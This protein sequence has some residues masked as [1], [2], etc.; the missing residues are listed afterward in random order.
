[1]KK[2][3]R[4]VVWAM[5][6][7]FLASFLTACGGGSKPA[8]EDSAA[9]KESS[10][11]ESSQTDSSKTKSGDLHEIY[12]MLDLIELDGVRP[13]VLEDRT[14]I[15]KGLPVE[16]KEKIT[17]GY[18]TGSLTTPFFTEVAE[19]QKRRA[20]Q[21]GFD[22]TVYDAKGDIQKQ[23]ADIE[24]MV[25]RKIDA[26]A[27]GPMDPRAN[28]LD[29]QRAADAGIIVIGTGIPFEDDVPLVTSFLANN[30]YSGWEAGKYA[31][32]KL[33]DVP[34]KAA[35]MFGSVGVSISEGRLNGMISGFLYKR[36]EQMGKPFASEEDAM[37]AGMK[38]YQ[39]FRDNGKAKLEEADIELVGYGQGQWST[40]GGL[41]AMEDLIVAH[42]DINVLFSDNDV[43]GEGAMMAMEQ[44]GMKVG[45]EVFIVCAADGARA[46]MDLIRDGKILV[47]GYQSPTQIGEA[48]VDLF[49][50]IFVEGYDAN[51]MPAT[52]DLPILAITK[53]NLD[54]FYDPNLEFAKPQPFKWKTIDEINAEKQ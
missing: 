23:S 11:T 19:S 53:E 34:I 18:T 2:V 16:K 52:T 40:N 21:Y 38:L 37:L 50:A 45:E 36:Y 26:I 41:T 43:M 1:M 48:I 39:E 42:P 6:F 14:H 7:I 3:N 20:Q 27:I 46:A 12:T 4:I 13:P 51:N 54:Q 24:A 8:G 32:E 9:P 31:A 22:F 47:T 10:Q 33:K 28:A 17:M 25:T 49:Y 15:Y 35:G 5:V 30:Y 44:A 29:I